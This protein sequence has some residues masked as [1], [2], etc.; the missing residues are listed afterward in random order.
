ML[1]LNLQWFGGR[2]SSSG[3]GST[4]H[5][6]TAT[7]KETPEVAESVK[8][9]QAIQNFEGRETFMEYTG[10]GKAEER[11][12]KNNSNADELISG[13]DSGTR[14]AFRGF[15][16]GDFMDGK[17]YGG[18]GNLSS[19]QKSS[20]RKIDAVLDR[21][22]LKRDITVVRAADGQFLL[23]KGKVH[24]TAADFEAVKGQVVKVPAYASAGAGKTGLDIGGRLGSNRIDYR[25]HV[26]KGTGRGMWVG[27]RRINYWGS[28]QREFLINRDTNYRID[29]VRTVRGRVV[30]DVT[31][32][33]H[34]AHDYG[35]G[36]WL[37][38]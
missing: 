4:S 33:G 14:D 32:V 27:D 11:F 24:A 8:E 12:F 19:Y 2:G 15:T 16:Q 6:F 28:R 34:E 3:T 22:T 7:A 17:L 5:T 9:A 21:A 20:A 18:W 23:G 38:W 30:V 37:K 36:G 1:V 26:P 25:I 29:N 31:V 13:M 35:K 10:N